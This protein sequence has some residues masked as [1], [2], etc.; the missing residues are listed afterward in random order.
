MD[1]IDD[2]ATRWG[3]PLYQVVLS[4]ALERIAFMLRYLPDQYHIARYFT[5]ML[6]DGRP[7]SAPRLRIYW[8]LSPRFIHKYVLTRRGDKDNC[9]TLKGDT[10]ECTFS[11]LVAFVEGAIK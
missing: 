3:A 7:T 8:N 6:E 4:E 11:P 1:R 9:W 5:E 10:L 2:F